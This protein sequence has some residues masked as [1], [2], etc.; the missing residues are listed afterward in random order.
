ML[1]QIVTNIAVI[2]KVSRRRRFGKWYFK[3]YRYVF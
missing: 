1:D 2:F 3:I